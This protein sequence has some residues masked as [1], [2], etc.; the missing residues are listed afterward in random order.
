MRKS[1]ITAALLVLLVAVL[2]PAFA[3]AAQ[4]KPRVGVLRFTNHTSAGWWSASVGRELSDMLA[5]EL[6]SAG[7]VRGPRAE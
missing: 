6:V 5:S 4:E 7:I 3:T 2:V 1:V